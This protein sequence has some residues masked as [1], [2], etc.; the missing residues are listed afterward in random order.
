MEWITELADV[1]APGEWIHLGGP[2]KT[3]ALAKRCARSHFINELSTVTPIYRVVDGKGVERHRTDGLRGGWRLNWQ[4]SKEERNTRDAAR[5]GWIAIAAVK[6]QAAAAGASD[7]TLL[8]EEMKYGLWSIESA[9]LAVLNRPE[10]TPEEFHQAW[11]D[12]RPGW[13]E[14]PTIDHRRLT[15][16]SLCDF[17]FL[18]EEERE[19]D[20]MFIEVVKACAAV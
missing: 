19:Y 10:I 14:G 7:P 3:E 2:Y 17:G 20:L 5:F 11:C 15:H 4:V 18:G 12:S 13:T 6:R 16:P 8:H 9:A 1:T